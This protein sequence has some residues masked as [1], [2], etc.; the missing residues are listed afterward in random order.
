MVHQMS[1][2]Q[3]MPSQVQWGPTH[4]R[5]MVLSSSYK[6]CSQDLWIIPWWVQKSSHHLDTRSLWV[7]PGMR[8][9]TQTHALKDRIFWVSLI[10]SLTSNPIECS[11]TTKSY[12]TQWELPTNLPM[13]AVWEMNRKMVWKALADKLLGKWIHLALHFKW[14]CNK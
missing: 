14:I 7:K 13:S 12:R 1:V 9:S 6:A 3:Q 5:I 8:I 10:Q 4:G 11:I 2:I